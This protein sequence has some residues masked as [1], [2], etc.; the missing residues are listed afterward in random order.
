MISRSTRKYIKPYYEYLL[1]LILEW[2]LDCNSDEYTFLH[3]TIPKDL[4]TAINNADDISED[5]KTCI[6]DYITD[7]NRYNEFVFTDRDFLPDNVANMTM[8]Y[9]DNRDMYDAIFRDINLDDYYLLMPRD[10]QDL[11]NVNIS[12][13]LNTPSR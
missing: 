13:Q 9:L 10:I 4:K 1:F 11:Y 8:L 5:E 6:A 2:Y 12:P 3:P 7:L